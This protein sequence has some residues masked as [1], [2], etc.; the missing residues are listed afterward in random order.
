MSDEPHLAYSVPATVE[1]DLERVRAHWTKLKRGGN[2]IPFWDDVK[3]AALPDGGSNAFL[4]D[5]FENPRR[6]RFGLLGSNIATRYSDP[7][8]GRFCDE[9]SPR[10][11]FD[12]LD[13]QC[14]ATVAQ[15]AQTYYRH[16]GSPP[17]G[18]LV[19]PLWG[20]GRMDMLLAAV[21]GA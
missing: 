9:V 17:Y 5:V 2:E 21:S 15:R 13:A 8:S 3:L 7:I 19:L 1:A 16:S 18:R 4:I 11:P 10:G 12:Q 6:F 20:N 14:A